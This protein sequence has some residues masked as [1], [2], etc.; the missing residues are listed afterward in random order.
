V[1]VRRAWGQTKWLKWRVFFEI[2]I[3]VRVYSARSYMN[4]SLRLT[5]ALNVSPEQA[6]RLTAL[7]AAFASVCNEISPVVQQTRCWNRVALHHMTYKLMRERFPLVGSQM[8]CNAIYSVSRM[9]RLLFQAQGSPLHI[10]KLEGRDLP[11]LRFADNCPVYF[12]R[13]TLSLKGGE[14]SMYTLDGRIK[15]Q[16]QLQAK[17]Q[18]AFHERKLKEIVLSR[19]PAGVFELS[20]WFGEAEES[21]PPPDALPLASTPVPHYVSLIGP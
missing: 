1:G 5:V 14:L 16:I 18:Q 13:H 4:T 6:A 3:G 8:V 7:Q 11:L 20:F 17:D 2:H 19:S 12:D 15:F 9:C 21:L 10:T